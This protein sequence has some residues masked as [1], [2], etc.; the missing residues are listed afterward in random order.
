MTQHRANLAALALVAIMNTGTK[1]ADFTITYDFRNT[2][3]LEVGGRPLSIQHGAGPLSSALTGTE[4][5]QCNP[6]DYGRKSSS[7]GQA[8]TM[9]AEAPNGFST[10]MV[11][12][13]TS[14]GGH[15]RTCVAGCDPFAGN[16]VGIVGH[17]TKATSQ[18][19]TYV[20]AKI[21]FNS[22]IL[23]NTYNL[24][25][26]PSQPSATSISLTKPDGTTSPV[27]TFTDAIPLQAKP[28]DTFFLRASI[29]ASAE[30]TGGCC[31][32]Q[33]DIAAQ[34]NVLLERAPI[35]SAKKGLF[36]YII[37]GKQT[38]LGAYTFVV[39]LLIDGELQCTGT[40]IGKK[41][42]LTAAHCIHGFE[43]QIKAGRMSVLIGQN[44]SQPITS[45]QI[46]SA[47][48]PRSTD[49]FQYD[50]KTFA[51][52]VAVAISKTE[53]QAR[54]QKIHSGQPPWSSLLNKVSLTFVGY[55]YNRASDGS[56]VAAGI[57]REAPWRADKA[58][59]W[60]F[61]Y[62]A[63]SKGLATTCSG[64]SGGPAFYQDPDTL[65]L[66]VVGITSGGDDNCTWGADTRVDT[67][68]DWITAHMQ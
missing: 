2:L 50:P 62:E 5:S 31:S 3:S 38:S 26:S 37:G 61:Y 52:D 67:H 64:D 24:R 8:S 17:D 44:I 11:V 43:D 20:E 40:L 7:S 32:D 60:R 6:S 55:G 33:K 25:L 23:Q 65:D 21:Q 9:I 13:T 49:S 48:Y 51:H 45:A 41:T 18:A 63:N 29:T 34:V 68:S 39:A 59:D 56:L 1:A 16:C 54:P 12:S 15:Y 53:L 58:D 47:T 22:D 19:S 66:M 35:L 27:L 30:N 14:A 46:V 10:K 42:I 57:L 4:Q 28:G 36:P